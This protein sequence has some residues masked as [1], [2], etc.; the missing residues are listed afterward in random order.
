MKTLT[1]WVMCTCLLGSG[2]A[3]AE[4][5]YYL[6]GGGVE[7]YTGALAS[8]VQPGVS[9]GAVVGYRLPFVGLELGYSGATSELDEGTVGVEQANG[10]DM[11]R[12]GG[13]I[14]ATIGIT[15][16]RVQPYLLGGI[17]IE[18]YQVS[19]D[20]LGGFEND[21]NGYV[22][23]GLG[24]RYQFGEVFAADAR[25]TYNFA[26]DREFAP[27]PADELSDSR[28]QFLLQLGGSY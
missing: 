13:Q 5:P 8:S 24:V 17:G 27:V 22:P 23:T 21:T 12:N 3:L 6:L 10:A 16:T 19:G 11:V 4:G 18:G 15:S 26:F 20:E 28:Y 14:A 2:A 9:Y 7:G 1:R 25:A